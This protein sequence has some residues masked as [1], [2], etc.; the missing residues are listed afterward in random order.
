MEVGD[1]GW[2]SVII[3]P[4]GATFALWKPKMG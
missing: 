1:H 3:D 2:L 4:T